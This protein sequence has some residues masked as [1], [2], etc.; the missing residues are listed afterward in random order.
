VREMQVQATS[1]NSRAM[2]CRAS[3]SVGRREEQ[4][5]R[6]SNAA[7]H[8]SADS[9]RPGYQQR[10]GLTALIFTGPPPSSRTEPLESGPAKGAVLRGLLD[11][12]R[13]DGDGTG[14]AV[15]D[16]DAVVTRHSARIALASS[17]VLC[18]WSRRRA[19]EQSERSRLLRTLNL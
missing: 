12:E 10:D 19:Q 3:P 7:H 14:R 17:L 15:G 5:R 11:A 16:L 13:G 1:E 8:A 6:T 2:E 18:A 4:H 9:E